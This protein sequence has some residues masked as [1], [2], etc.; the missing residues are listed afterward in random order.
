MVL[1]HT[2]PAK[3]G[4][5]GDFH[6]VTGEGEREAQQLRPLPCGAS[7]RMGVRP[8]NR[9]DLRRGKKQLVAGLHFLQGHMFTSFLN[10]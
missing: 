8:Q 4:E 3:E 10:G 7:H 2:H 6:P 9:G 5:T 1:H